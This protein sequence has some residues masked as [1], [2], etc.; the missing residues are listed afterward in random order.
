VIKSFLQKAGLIVISIA[1]A[2]GIGEA[3]SRL[4]EQDP[5]QNY[6]VAPTG[7]QYEFYQ[8]DKLLG[9]KNSPGAHGIFQ[10]DEF[11]Y[12]ISINRYG[13]RQKEVDMKPGPDVFRVAFLGD[14]FVWGIGVP[15]EQRFTDIVG[16]RPGV[17]ALN[18]GVSGYSPVQYYL[19]IDKV[20]AFHPQ[21]VV[22]AS[23]SNDFA[24]N[25]LYRRYGY[26]KPYAVL[27]GE[28]GIAIKGYPIRNV[29]RFGARD[30]ALK[31][32]WLEHSHLYRMATN[33]L[34]QKRSSSGQRGLVGFKT[35]YQY[36]ALDEQYRRLRDISITVNT[37]LMEKI[38][39]RLDK[40]GIPLAIITAPT[41]FEY[42][43]S[44]QYGNFIRDNQVAE[45]L[46]NTAAD[47]GIDLI[48]TIPLLDGY[49]FWVRDGHWNPHGHEKMAAAMVDYLVNAGYI[50]G[51]NRSS[52]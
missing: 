11:R 31:H 40:A 3:A 25:V 22:I 38:K 5:G 44:G 26:Y 49:D 8:F 46:A 52:Q 47:L 9:W 42:N 32:D 39:Q 20:I 21:L 37:R 48:N 27:D 1:I 28:G 14:S 16:A 6:S 45:I 12:E 2:V 18:F 29:N 41:K 10:R 43:P 36:S 24:D 15:D 17:E 33:Y 30:N 51:N 50:S 7:N 23:C 19:M 34:D 4:L 35:I 13:M